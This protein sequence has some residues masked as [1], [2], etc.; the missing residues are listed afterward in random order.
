MPLGLNAAHRIHLLCL[1]TSTLAER[2]SATI[3]LRSL[4]CFETNARIFPYFLFLFAHLARLN[5]LLKISMRQLQ[6]ISSQCRYL[7]SLF[8]TFGIKRD[9][10]VSMRLI[11]SICFAWQRPTLAE[12][13]SD[14]HRR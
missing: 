4:L 7:S 1:A 5:L 9:L 11:A 13:K 14:Y 10:S 8:L 6:S 3:V 12:R 2:K